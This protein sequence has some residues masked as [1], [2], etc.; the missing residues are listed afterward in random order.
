MKNTVVVI[1]SLWGDEGKG[2]ITNFLSGQADMV[3]RYAGGDNAGHTIVLDGET[4]KL[5]L[6]PSGVFNPDVK[7][8]LANGMV[9]NPRNLLGEIKDLKARGVLCENLYI[10]ERAQVIFDS[11]LIL[12]DLHEQALGKNKI[13]TTKKGIGPAYEDKVSR[14]GIRMVDFISADFKTIYQEFVERHNKEIVELGGKPVDFKTS[15]AEYC[16]IAQEL[17]PHIVDSVTLINDAITDGDKIVLEGAQGALLDVDFGTYPFVTSSNPSIGGACIGSGIPATKLN[18]VIGVSKAYC[19]RVG[20]GAFPTEMFDDLGSQIR[21]RG[22]EYGTTTK[23]PRRIGWFDAVALN[24]S[25]MINGFTGIAL[26][27]LDVLTGIPTLRIATSYNLDGKT[28]HTL[29]AQNE[30]CLRCKPNY[31]ELPGWKEDITKCRTFASLPKN[32]QD[33]V[34]TIEECTGVPVVFVSVGPDHDATIVRKELFK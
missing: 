6:V 32:A 17:K 5:H 13:G 29:P 14:K 8:V 21:E 15:Y 34:K 25:I 3:V 31:I 9:I 23:R 26:M 12:D 24:Y 28:I 27:L 18:E 4:Y 11:H 19:T 2:K 16:K 10:G 7:N 1:G 22:H 20:A 33:Y 30:L